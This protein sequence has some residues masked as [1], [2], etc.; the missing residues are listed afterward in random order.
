[1]KWVEIR[2]AFPNQWIVVEALSAH[3]DSLGKRVITDFSLIE[4]CADSTAAFN[5]YRDLHKKNSCKEYYFLHTS[6]E[7]LEIEER[8]WVG[9]RNN[10]ANP[11]SL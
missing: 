11:A 8:P 4:P 9:I 1:M 2:L 10:Y 3:T 6:K 7:T 5:K